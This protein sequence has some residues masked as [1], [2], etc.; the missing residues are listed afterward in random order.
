METANL[1]NPSTLEAGSELDNASLSRMNVY[2]SPKFRNNRSPTPTAS[3]ESCQLDSPTASQGGQNYFLAD[4]VKFIKPTLIGKSFATADDLDSESN[5]YVGGSQM[6]G[7]A[8]QRDLDAYQGVNRALSI[9]LD[10]LDVA[11]QEAASA[12]S[13]NQA[14]SLEQTVSNMVIPGVAQKA[15]LSNIKKVKRGIKD[16]MKNSFTRSIG[17]SSRRV[18]NPNLPTFKAVLSD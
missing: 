14:V 12:N 4:G 2:L 11:Q 18:P 8:Q 3:S 7:Q 13:L 1:G 10:T 15:M 6:Q 17:S 9:E 16:E 5:Y